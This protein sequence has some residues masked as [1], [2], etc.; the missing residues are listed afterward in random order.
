MR[1]LTAATLPCL[2]GLLLALVSLST[3]AGDSA[4]CRIGDISRVFG[5]VQIIR[6]GNTLVPKAGEAFCA[7]DRF[8]TNS[9]GVTELAFRDGSEITVGKNTEFTIERWQERRFFANEATFALVKGAFRALTGA[10][11][12][13]RHRVE[14]RTAI[15]TIGVRGTEFWGG[16]NLTPNALEVVMLGGKGVYVKNDAGTVE[17]TEAGTGTTVQAGKTPATPDAWSPEKVQRAVATI[18]P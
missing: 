18:T 3:H 14:V 8:L 2:A 13:R 12:Q 15:A 1:R 16:L 7:G 10:I 4:A 6:G 5:G 11:T 9:K 17:L